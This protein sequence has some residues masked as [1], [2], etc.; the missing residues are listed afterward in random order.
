MIEYKDD[1]FGAI[2]RAEDILDM[3]QKM[4][5][6]DDIRSV[7]FG[8][9]DELAAIRNGINTPTSL[10]ERLAELEKEMNSLRP[11]G[12]IKAYDLVDIQK[13]LKDLK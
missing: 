7:H 13:E 1:R 8:T 11:K 3:L 2:A 6:L 12:N 4:P 9:V 10:H 5:S